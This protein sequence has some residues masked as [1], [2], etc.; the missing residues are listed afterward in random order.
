[1]ILMYDELGYSFR[2]VT[3]LVAEGLRENGYRI[4]HLAGARWT[5]YIPKTMKTILIG[6]TILSKKLGWIDRIARTIKPVL[7]CDTPIELE[8]LLPFNYDVCN[9]VTLPNQVK[10]Y[11]RVGIKVHGWIPRPVDF[12]LARSISS[13]CRDLREK[14]GDYIVTVGGDQVLL[15]PRV[16]RKGLDMYDK[17]CEKLSGRVRCVAVSNWFFRHVHKIQIGSLS[18]VDLFRLIKCAKLFVWPSR[19]EGFGMPPIEAM[20][21][22]QVVV[23]S[24]APF[25]ELVYGVKFDYS[26]VRRVFMPEVGRYYYAHDYE[27]DDLYEAVDYALSLDEDTRAKIAEEA[28]RR[29]SLLDKRLVAEALVEV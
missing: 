8:E 25:N 28:M 14:Y 11:S 13:D 4:V 18:E 12:K 9:Y 24:N 15:P 10:L 22:G 23:A 17:L 20:A 2:K 5:L 1:M 3:R 6:D 21:V 16:P 7:W 19:A 29:A 27:L 26:D